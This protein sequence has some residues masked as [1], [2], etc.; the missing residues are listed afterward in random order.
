MEKI[1]K[2]AAGGIVWS[3]LCFYSWLNVAFWGFPKT[4]EDLL[5]MR[6]TKIDFLFR[7]IFFR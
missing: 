2:Y 6:Y 3:A 4:T 7:D 5:E 1:L